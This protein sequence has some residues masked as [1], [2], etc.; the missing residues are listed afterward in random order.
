MKHGCG[1]APLFACS[2]CL[3]VAYCSSECATRD[4]QNGHY[5]MC[6]GYGSTDV[7]EEGNSD[8]EEEQRRWYWERQGRQSP[9]QNA[10]RDSPYTVMVPEYNEDGSLERYSGVPTNGYD[11]PLTRRVKR[12]RPREPSLSGDESPR[13]RG[14]ALN[15]L[16]DSNHDDSVAPTQIV[17]S[18][19]FIF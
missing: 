3:S 6:N 18:Q 13:R 8:W 10:G 11:T 12:T 7:D 14:R 16:D 1:H 9:L 5:A 15:F 17:P 19:S 4:W 2:K